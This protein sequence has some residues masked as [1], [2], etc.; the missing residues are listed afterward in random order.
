M[1][2]T[3]ELDAMTHMVSHW[4]NFNAITDSEARREIMQLALAAKHCKILEAIQN[5][6]DSVAK[7]MWD[8]S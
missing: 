1:P 5:D 3:D 6:T 2:T 7:V 8:K 4:K